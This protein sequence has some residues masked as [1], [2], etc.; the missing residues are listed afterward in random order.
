MEFN[1]KL[2][3]VKKQYTPQSRGEQQV[4]NILKP[5]MGEQLGQLGI[6]SLR[7]DEKLP[8][9]FKFL[10]GTTSGT[11]GTVE[12]NGQK[13][14]YNIVGDQLVITPESEMKNK[15]NNNSSLLYEDYNWGK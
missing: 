4:L 6:R 5:L 2:K 14:D 11:G 9:G 3:P 1:N 12:F 15:Y 13:Y 8:R 10:A 7:K